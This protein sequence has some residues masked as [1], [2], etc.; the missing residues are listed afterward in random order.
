MLQ[1]SES[2]LDPAVLQLLERLETDTAFAPQLVKP[3]AGRNHVLRRIHLL[4]K[5][6]LPFLNL[7]NTPHISED[8]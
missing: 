1:V 3:Q 4:A 8:I 7:F 5:E 6:T 2:N